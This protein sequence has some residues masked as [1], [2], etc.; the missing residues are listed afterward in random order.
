MSHHSGFPF[1]G[2]ENIEDFF[3]KKEAKPVDLKSGLGATGNFPDGKLTEHDEGEIKIGITTKDGKVVIDFGKPVHWI[4]F[5]KE[6]AVR[7]ATSL[8][9]KAESL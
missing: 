7:I 5:T 2:K 3:K 8:L 4:G 9:S 1:E 6:Q